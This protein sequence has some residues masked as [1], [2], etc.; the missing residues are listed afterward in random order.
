MAA[1]VIHW[2]ETGRWQLKILGEYHKRVTN[3]GRRMWKWG[4]RMHVRFK[5]WMTSSIK[6]TESGMQQ[7]SK[8][9][10]R[11]E[12]REEG[13][14]QWKAIE[15]FWVFSVDLDFNVLLSALENS[16]H[17]EIA[18]RKLKGW[19][20]RSSRCDYAPVSTHFTVSAWRSSLVLS[21]GKWNI[22]IFDLFVAQDVSRG[23]HTFCSE[24]RPA[25][26]N[27]WVLSTI[28]PSLCC[29]CIWWLINFLTPH[30]KAVGSTYRKCYMFC[31]AYNR[32]NANKTWTDEWKYMETAMCSFTHLK[33]GQALLMKYV[34][35][36]KKCQSSSLYSSS[37]SCCCH[38]L[39]SLMNGTCT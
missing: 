13:R 19:S 11:E 36:E 26:M 31:S 35:L 18:E 14:A 16:F 9:G 8:D 4:T 21:C 7:C 39:S 3:Q 37:F 32:N 24:M 25:G 29:I 27:E 20:K 17:D 15:L 34:N 1:I 30:L 10:G 22:N 12:E 38:R 33:T 5:L 2:T 28:N 6:Q 23:W